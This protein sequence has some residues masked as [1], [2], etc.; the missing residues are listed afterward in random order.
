MIVIGNKLKLNDN[1]LK[2]YQADTGLNTIPT[3][4]EQYNQNLQNAADFWRKE[5]LDDPS[6]ELLAKLIE[7]N[8]VA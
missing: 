8:K 1:E 3:T 6:A 5:A 7:N 4:V 2:I